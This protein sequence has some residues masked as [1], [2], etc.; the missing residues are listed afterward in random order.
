MEL[1]NRV[2]ACAE[3]DRVKREVGVDYLDKWGLG[4]RGVI[5]L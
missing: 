4:R 1:G 2:G 5:V 3:G